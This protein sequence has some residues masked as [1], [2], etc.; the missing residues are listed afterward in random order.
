MAVPG[1]N[2]GNPLPG[3]WAGTRGQMT[4]VSFT[5][6]YGALLRGDVFAPLPGARDPYTG[7]ALEGPSPAW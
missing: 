6:R 5:N 7:E 4:P 3:G 2:V 1:W